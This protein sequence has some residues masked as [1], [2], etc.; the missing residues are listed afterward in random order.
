MVRPNHIFTKHILSFLVTCERTIRKHSHGEKTLGSKNLPQ[1]PTFHVFKTKSDKL[2]KSR[3]DKPKLKIPFDRYQGTSTA[4]IRPSSKVDKARL[5][6]RVSKDFERP[7]QLRHRNFLS[8]TVCRL[9]QR[10]TKT[11]TTTLRS[12]VTWLKSQ[13]SWRATRPKPC[14]SKN[15]LKN[16]PTLKPSRARRFRGLGKTQKIPRHLKKFQ[17]RRLCHH[18]Y[19]TIAK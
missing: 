2:F 11:K 19:E 17:S 10:Q 3:N 1:L 7:N 12:W 15:F 5:E 13:V 6:R 4:Q 16:A 14:S 8:V 9:R 18:S